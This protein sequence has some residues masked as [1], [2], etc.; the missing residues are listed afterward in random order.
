MFVFVCQSVKFVFEGQGPGRIG[1]RWGGE[2]F[3]NMHQY[4]SADFLFLVTL[5]LF[6][7]LFVL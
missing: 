7:L 3:P 5:F 4:V 1:V 2:N 6:L